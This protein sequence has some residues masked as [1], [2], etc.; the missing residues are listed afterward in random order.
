M[1]FQRKIS[2]RKVPVRSLFL[3][4]SSMAAPPKIGNKET[5]YRYLLSDTPHRIRKPEPQRAVQRQH[6]S[7]CLSHRHCAALLGSG[8]AAQYQH[9]QQQTITCQKIKSSFHP[10]GHFS[11]PWQGDKPPPASDPAQR[12]PTTYHHQAQMYTAILTQPGRHSRTGF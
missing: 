1:S 6:I 2:A 3:F 11:P 10:T 5:D 12:K 8:V 7:L 4:L 9:Q